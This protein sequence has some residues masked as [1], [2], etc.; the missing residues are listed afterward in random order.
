MNTIPHFERYVQ[1]VY[2]SE[3]DNT[4]ITKGTKYATNTVNIMKRM[5]RNNILKLDDFK[6]GVTLYAK[7]MNDII[8]VNQYTSAI[9]ARKSDIASYK[10]HIVHRDTATSDMIYTLSATTISS[11]VNAISM[12]SKYMGQ[13]YIIINLLLKRT[14]IRSHN[15]QQSK[16]LIGFYEPVPHVS[17]Y[18]RLIDKLRIRQGHIFHFMNQNNNI[19]DD[20]RSSRF[21]FGTDE[22]R[23]FIILMLCLRVIP[24]KSREIEL[25]TLGE[26]RTDSMP[27]RLTHNPVL[28]MDT[29]DRF[30]ISINVSSSNYVTRTIPDDIGVYIRHYLMFYRE[31]KNSEN[32]MFHI[33]RAVEF[34]RVYLTNIGMTQSDR[35]SIGVEGGH[36]FIYQMRVMYTVIAYA[37]S[38]IRSS[39]NIQMIVNMANI[40]FATSTNRIASNNKYKGLESID[41]LESALSILGH[42]LPP[43]YNKCGIRKLHPIPAFVVE[44]LPKLVNGELLPWVKEPYT[45]RVSERHKRATEKFS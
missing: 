35:I 11:W 37:V 3:K 42:T 38:S 39:K 34:I 26:M 9:V 7:I 40:G 29:H 18:N 13:N 25:M 8:M 27:E 19:D 24:L 17:W 32:R 28:Y 14:S 36:S 21:K 15:L 2:G 6:N 16:V 10:R 33:S 41:T 1:L 12:Y 43:M 31:N 23:L 45:T 22:L 44:I 30:H 20:S 4:I 5:F